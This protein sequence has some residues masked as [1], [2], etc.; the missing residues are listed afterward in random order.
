M[1]TKRRKVKITYNKILLEEFCR[2]SG[3]KYSAIAQKLGISQTSF[4]NKRLGVYDFT[5]SEISKLSEILKL[6][7][8]NMVDIFFA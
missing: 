6:S 2:K 1:S 4:R 8:K 3:L 5:Q 7:Q